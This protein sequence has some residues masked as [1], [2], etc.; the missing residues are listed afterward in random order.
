[1]RRSGDAAGNELRL[2]LH[3]R[4]SHHDGG[5]CF[6]AKI[7]RT[8]AISL[9]HSEGEQH[10]GSRQFRFVR[11][12]SNRQPRTTVMSRGEISRGERQVV[13]QCGPAWARDGAD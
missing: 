3:R 11:Q 7:D 5:A 10:V 4:K 2:E 8:E 1:L 9:T 6:A 13:L 12:G